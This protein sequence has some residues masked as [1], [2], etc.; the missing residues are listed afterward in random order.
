[1]C[2]KSLVGLAEKAFSATQGQGEA[3]SAD[4]PIMAQAV[5]AVVRERQAHGASAFLVEG[6][7]EEEAKNV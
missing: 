6:E 1:M 5:R 2:S 7:S 3:H 4:M